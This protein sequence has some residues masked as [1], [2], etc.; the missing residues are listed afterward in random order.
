VGVLLAARK[1]M[2]TVPRQSPRSGPDRKRQGRPMS[3]RRQLAALYRADCIDPL[4][5]GS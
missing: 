5:E 2:A 1:G 3:F 4:A